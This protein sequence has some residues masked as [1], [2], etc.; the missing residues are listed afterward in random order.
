MKI[1]G[2]R[3]VILL[4]SILT[5]FIG[6]DMESVKEKPLEESRALEENKSAEERVALD[7]SAEVEDSQT[8]EKIV[9]VEEKAN[10]E[11]DI[12]NT[13]TKRNVVESEGIIND[14]DNFT[15]I[16]Y[17]NQRFGYDIK[18]PSFLI[19]KFGASN[20][21]GI[22]AENN[23]KTVSFIVYGSN[24]SLNQDSEDAFNFSNSV[25]PFNNIIYKS[26]SDEF[27]IVSGEEDGSIYYEY[28][29][30]GTGSINTFRIEYPKSDKEYFDPIVA[31]IYQSFIPGD[32]SKGW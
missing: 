13:D 18:Y 4:L 15:Y 6:C 20:N 30:V 28:S 5:I 25:R 26:I 2:A 3:V 23:D 9:R 10:N 19:N 1:R 8:E 14:Y 22:T 21:D 12:V 27:Y 32:L 17:Y 7:E 29:I 24:N 31:E 11:E 16:N